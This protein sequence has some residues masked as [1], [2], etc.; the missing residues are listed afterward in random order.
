MQTLNLP[1]PL[2][3]HLE[4]TKHQNLF[5]FMWSSIFL[6]SP[7]MSLT[8]SSAHLTAHATT[9]SRNLAMSLS[10]VVVEILSRTLS[11]QLITQRCSRSCQNDKKKT[12]RSD[13]SHL[14]VKLEQKKCVHNVPKVHTSHIKHIVLDLFN[15]CTTSSH[16]VS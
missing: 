6:V 12:N 10:V 8:C 11:S 7:G 2:S 3:F 4:T 9:S 13:D 1:R 14:S 5:L 15:V 16:A